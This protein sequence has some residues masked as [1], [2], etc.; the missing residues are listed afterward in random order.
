MDYRRVDT[1]GSSGG[2]AVSTVWLG[3]VYTGTGPPLI[4]ETMVFTPQGAAARTGW[5]GAVNGRC[6]M[7]QS[8][9]TSI[10]SS[11][12]PSTTFATSRR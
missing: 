11:G 9:M 8:T 10:V 5:G 4:F 12:R 7:W 1:W 3:L 6:Q 2:Y